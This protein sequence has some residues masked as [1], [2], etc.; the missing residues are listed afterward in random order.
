MS[1]GIGRMINKGSM[2][3]STSSPAIRVEIYNQT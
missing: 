1:S 2:E 3:G